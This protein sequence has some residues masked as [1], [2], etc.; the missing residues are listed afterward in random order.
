MSDDRQP[1]RDPG[2]PLRDG[3]R[4]IAGILGALK[5]AIEETFDELRQ[6]GELSP[7]RA[8]DAARSTFRKAQETVDDVRGRFDFVAKRDFDALRAEVD[9]LRSR[10]DALETG[11]TATGAPRPAADTATQSRPTGEAASGDRPD[12]TPPGDSR[13]RFEVE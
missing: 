1:P 8:R 2:D 6:S 5:D 13:Y 11:G 4:S 9:E 7:E 10:I 12:E 3:V